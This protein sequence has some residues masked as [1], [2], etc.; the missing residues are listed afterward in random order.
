MKEKIVIRFLLVWTIGI[1]GGILFSLLRIF[2]RIKV[3]GYERRKFIPT[4]EGLIIYYNHPSLLEPTILPF[5]LFPHYLF[6]KSMIPFSAP[7]KK[8]YYDQ[9]WFLPFRLFSIPIEREGKGRIESFWRIFQKVRKG[10]IVIIAP[11]GGRTFKGEEF[12]VIEDGEIKVKKSWSEVKESSQKIR[13]FKRG[14]SFLI[15]KTRATVLPIWTEG[16]EKIWK[17]MK[18]RI[19]EPCR[20]EDIS[21]LEDLENILL[22][23][24]GAV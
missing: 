6:F 17:K 12:K 23:C 10:G 7:D 22:K 13:R 14:I 20:S 18:I 1:W 5:L 19:G 16:G 9:W 3:I 21:S 2:G 24:S 8:N 15:Q 4:K 11:E